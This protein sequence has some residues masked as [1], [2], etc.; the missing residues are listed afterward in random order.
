MNRASM[1]ETTLLRRILVVIRFAHC[2]AVGPS[3]ESLSP[4]TVIRTRCVSALLG[5]VDTTIRPH[6]TLLPAGTSEWWMK[7]I[8]FVPFMRFPTPCT[9]LPMS[10]EKY[11]VQV[12]LLGPH[13]SCVYPWVFPVAGSSTPWKST[14]PSPTVFNVWL[15]CVR[16]RR[17]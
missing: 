12:P 3:Y 10:L 2:V 4:P 15:A 13:I 8:L 16:E 11:V 1:V 17:G 5:L 14:A 7:K 6:V 9:S